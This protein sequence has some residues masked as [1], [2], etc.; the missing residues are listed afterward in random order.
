[1]KEADGG[2]L[3]GHCVANE[4]ASAVFDDTPPTHLSGL[5]SLGQR[6]SVKS[7]EG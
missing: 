4:L 1:L 5:A 6:Y 3:A 7:P 2:G